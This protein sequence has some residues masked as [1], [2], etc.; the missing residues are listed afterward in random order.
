[1]GNK[2][3][4]ATRI[5]VYLTFGPCSMCREMKLNINECDLFGTKCNFPGCPL[6][7]LTS[8]LNLWDLIQA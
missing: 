5:P 1:M 7:K 8:K 3:S 2:L 6:E 4:K